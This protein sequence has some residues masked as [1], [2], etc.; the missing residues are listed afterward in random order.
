MTSP[1]A[2]AVGDAATRSTGGPKRRS[3]WRPTT[4]RRWT[5]AVLLYV[6]AI[7]VAA[8]FVVPF[9]WMAVSSLKLPSDVLAY[10]P[11]WI[12]SPA[13]G[14]NYVD[15]FASGSPWLTYLRNSIIVSGLVVV[16]STTSSTLV[17]FGFARLHVKGSA[18][19]FMAM[20]ATLMIP[21]TVTLIPTYLVYARLGLVNTFVPLV[22]PSFLGANVAG[23]FLLRQFFLTMPPS[24]EDSAR[25][26]GCTWLG[27]LV[28]IF[29]PN[30]GP[31]LVATAVMAF[32]ATWNDFLAPLIFFTSPDK[33]TLP[34]GIS[35]LLNN[36]GNV[37]NPGFLMAAS[38]IGL[39]PILVFFF[40]FQRFYMTINI[41]SGLK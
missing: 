17:A 18:A 39:L 15:F 5:R 21:V 20:L 2:V 11:R 41:T 10:P 37:N 23:T 16:G 27:V 28:R 9:A 1:S 40:F 22:L 33:Y 8:L 14:R 24:L 30:C 38:V 31:A 4:R 29:L 7:V 34:L 12:P 6:I 26:D 32:V 36:A 35:T 25:L 3:M 13:T 19:L